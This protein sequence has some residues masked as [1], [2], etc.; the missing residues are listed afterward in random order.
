MHVRNI[1]DRL[2]CAGRTEAARKA[3]ALGLLGDDRNP[4]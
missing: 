3:A 2:D 1:L 4:P